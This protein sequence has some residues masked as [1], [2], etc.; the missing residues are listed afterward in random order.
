[1]APYKFYD[2]DYS[3]SYNNYYNYTNGSKGQIWHHMVSADR[4]A[5]TEV[6]GDRAPAGSRAWSEG[7]GPSTLKL[8]AFFAFAQREELA[9]L[10]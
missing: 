9:N 8:K 2:S 10:S 5:M 3:H 4:E 6:R 1:V 7:Q